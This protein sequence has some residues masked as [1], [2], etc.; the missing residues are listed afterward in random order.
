MARRDGH[1]IDGANGRRDPLNLISAEP[2][3]E[4]GRLR[5][6]GALSR[7]SKTKSQTFKARVVKDD[8]T[9]GCGI[10]LPWDPKEHFGKTRAPVRATINGHTFRTTT[11]RMCGVHWFPLNKENRAAAGVEAGDVVTVKLELDEAPRVIEPPTEL[12]AA[13][14]RSKKLQTAWGKLSYSCRRE[15][16]QAIN[17]A[18]KPETRERR[19]EKTIEALKE[20]AR[21]ARRRNTRRSY[22]AIATTRERAAA[23]GNQSNAAEC[24]CS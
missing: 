20:R 6:E 13:L 2:R 14:K 11:F 3:L 22:G 18:K 4:R 23:Q 16:A 8:D 10:E 7:Q 9:S 12:A 1:E 17:E 15:Y 21:S 24:H 19:V 5:R